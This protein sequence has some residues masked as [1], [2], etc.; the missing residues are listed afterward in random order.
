MI[1]NNRLNLLVIDG[2]QLYA[3]RIVELLSSYYDNVNLGFLDDK[4]EF[5]KLLRRKWD[6]LVYGRAYDMKLTD[7]VSLVQ[8]HN[9]D[10]PIIGLLSDETAATGR[11]LEGL[12]KV[13]DSTLIKAINPDQETQIILSIILQHQAV[14]TRR[15]MRELHDIVDEAEQRANI[16]IKNSKSAVAYIDEGI[17]I[18]ANQPYL[19]MFGFNSLDDLMGVP[20]IDLI[21]GGDDVKGFKQFLRRFTKGNRDNV[22]FEFE[23]KRQD[24]STFEAK[25]QLASAT[26]EGQPVVQVIIQQNNTGSGDAAE[27]AKKLA[28]VERLD[29]LTG[30]ENRLGFMEKLSKV[31]KEVK[32]SKVQAGLMYIRL[33]SLGKINSSL[34]LQGV[35][36]TIKQV[37]HSLDEY[38]EEDYV[39]RFSDSI[40]TVIVHE[41]D[42]KLLQEL[43]L[44]IQQRVDNML[45]EVGKRTADT[46]LS[47]GMTLIDENSPEAES[48][49]ERAV[50]AYNQVMAK[51]DNQ[52][53]GC[54]LYDPSQYVSSDNDALVE[55]LKASLNNNNFCL[56]YQPIYDI[57]T[58][59]SATFEVYLSL[60]LSDGDIMHPNEFVPVAQ[61]NH[62]LNKID[63]WLLVNACK[64]L[65]QVR[66]KHPEAGIIIRLSAE[67]LIDEQLPKIAG[68]LIK[69]LG[70]DPTALTL[71]FTEPDV[72]TYLTMAK[73]QFA[74]LSALK[75]RVSIQDFGSSAKALEVIE[76]VKPDIARLANSY[77]SDLSNP[78]DLETVKTLINNAKGQGVDVLMPYI[79]EASTM[80]VAWSVG[81]RYLQG[82]Y[83][84][85]PTEEMTFGE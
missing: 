12:P 4:K 35:D 48:V 79:E 61:A 73:K 60:K 20:V 71:Q 63:R 26:Y 64:Q 49:L 7:V 76:F 25:L 23:S 31:C 1:E 77:V 70:G 55:Y 30:L 78:D 72:V 85:P 47:I 38:F 8:E 16:L 29:S 84:E 57:D 13:I 69:A 40:F 42:D 41:T 67:T 2:N 75:C 39:S 3:E 22:E 51:T 14:R 52:G 9:I 74:A 28:E 37:A 83:L 62:L 21:S 15:K 17:H 34:G 11:N 45:I 5:I 50:E 36:T 44:D 82:N 59:S 33:D 53:N 19:E 32:S 54:H 43:A 27:I 6:V 66:T 65:N 24:D 18:F 58:D 10:L 56:S 46:T 68:Q 81:A 80:S